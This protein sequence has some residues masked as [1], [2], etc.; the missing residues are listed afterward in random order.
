MT[1]A[2]HVFRRISSGFGNRLDPLLL[3]CLLV[4]KKKLLACTR[5][6]W[7][8][9]REIQEKMLNIKH[10]IIRQSNLD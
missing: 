10:G 4:F 2:S 9:S 6:I 1:D 8:E 7:F 3:A 5:Y